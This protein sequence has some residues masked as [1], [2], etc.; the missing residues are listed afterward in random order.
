MARRTRTC[1][2]DVRSALRAELGGLG[3]GKPLRAP[4]HAGGLSYRGEVVWEDMNMTGG[5][6]LSVR[7]SIWNF[8]FY[9]EK[10]VPF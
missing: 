7:V 3:H 10:Q 4:S 9:Y 1:P 2:R 5:P 6:I 8:N